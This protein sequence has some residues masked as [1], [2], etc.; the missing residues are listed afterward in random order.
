MTAR[1]VRC[2]GLPSDLAGPS[3]G[4]EGQSGRRTAARGPRPNPQ[5]TPHPPPTGARSRIRRVT[6]PAACPTNCPK[7]VNHG[8]RRLGTGRHRGRRP[9]RRARP[10]RG[11]RRGPP[12]RHPR[13]LRNHPP[14]RPGQPAVV[15]R[16]SAHPAGHHGPRPHRHGR[17]QR[18]RRRRHLQPGRS[19]LRPHAAV[20]PAPVDPGPGGEP[21][22]G[23]PPGRGDRCRPRPTD[24]RA[25]RSVLGRVLGGGPV[26]PQLPHHRHRVHRG[27]PGPPLL[28]DQPVRLGAHRRRAR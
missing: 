2:Q 19:E 5:S 13:R 26:H 15:A 7:E 11:A 23:G 28:R 20:D 16:P 9:R 12:R 3:A 27:Q 8:R 10:L 25:V 17:R 6:G 18:R 22:D 1:E 14:A 24:Q 4:H 21:G